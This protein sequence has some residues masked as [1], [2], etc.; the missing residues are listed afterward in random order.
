MMNSAEGPTPRRGRRAG[1]PGTREQILAVARHRF[2]SEGYHAVTLRSVAAGA[3]VD[4]ALVS[5]YFGSKKG[6]FGAALALTGNPAVLLVEALEGELETFPE[7]ALRLLLGVWDAPDS[8]GPLR[9]M[10]GGAAQDPAVALLVSEVVQ[11]E[12]VDRI[13]GRLG[14]ADARRRACLFGTQLAGLIMAR[15]V[16]CLQPLASLSADE[17]ARSYLPLLRQA[18]WGRSGRPGR[19]GGAAGGASGA[20]DRWVAGPGA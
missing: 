1:S 2:L 5:Y 20:G 18:L 12:M 9:A 8:A 19:P 13:A 7:R 6:L 10:I 4:L 3:G 14:G 15:Y 17:I 16:L 11:R